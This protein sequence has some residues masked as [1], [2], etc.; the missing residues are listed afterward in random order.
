MKK[1]IFTFF[2]LSQAIL[3]RSLNHSVLETIELDSAPTFFF[4]VSPDGRYY[5]YT[6]PSDPSRPQSGGYNHIYDTHTQRAHRIPGPWD[7]VFNVGSEFIT[8]P[9]Q[10][11]NTYYSFY[12]IDDVLEN[13]RSAKPIGSDTKLRGL[14]QSIGILK[15][16]N[17]EIV[18]RIIAE[19]INNH[20]MRDYLFSK[21]G[22][23]VTPIGPRKELCPKKKI[24]L[25]MI[26]KDGQ[27]LGA[28][29][30]QTGKTTVY[31][32]Q[33]D[34]SCHKLFDLGQKFGKVNFSFDKRY[35]TFHKYNT[36]KPKI[37][38]GFV[39]IP[40]TKTTSDIYIYDRT[41]KKTSQLTVNKK[42]NSL[43]PDFLIDGNLTYINYPH[44]QNKKIH[45]VKIQPHLYSINNEKDFLENLP[46]ENREKERFREYVSIY[47]INNP[48]IRVN[49][50]KTYQRFLPIVE[51]AE[52]LWPFV[53]KLARN[54]FKLSNGNILR[55][56]LRVNPQLAHYLLS[57][58]RFID[59]QTMIKNLTYD[60]TEGKLKLHPNI[61]FSLKKFFIRSSKAPINNNIF[62]FFAKSFEKEEDLLIDLIL[63]AIDNDLSFIQLNLF[64]RF[65][66]NDASIECLEILAEAH[67]SLDQ[68]EAMKRF[69]NSSQINNLTREKKTIL[70]RYALKADVLEITSYATLNKLGV[71]LKEID[72]WEQVL[73]RAQQ[74]GLDSLKE[75]AILHFLINLN[76]KKSIHKIA[77][78]FQ[79][80]PQKEYAIN[81]LQS[82]IA[83]NDTDVLAEQW[84]LIEVI[85]NKFT[86][87]INI[88]NKL[89]SQYKDT[90]IYTNLVDYSLLKEIQIDLPLK[91]QVNFINR[92]S[93]TIPP[94]ISLRIIEKVA[95]ESSLKE[96]LR[97]LF[98]EMVLKR[99]ED[100][101]NEFIVGFLDSVKI[102]T[103][104][105]DLRDLKKVKKLYKN[106]GKI[107]I[108]RKAK[109]YIKSNYGNGNA[110]TTVGPLFNF[111]SSL[112][113]CTN[114]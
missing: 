81:I 80:H 23:S 110:N 51:K 42:S 107:C 22:R 92:H 37:T 101:E 34:G 35:L 10:R 11:E 82:L 50:Y 111:V 55:E 66:K 75:E 112:S 20:S 39:A 84:S 71:L 3:A 57:E 90:F 97:H 47:L 85:A 79:D 29:D 36:N 4:K 109:K 46:S 64:A 13:G 98:N 24:K 21:G 88:F 86:L 52:L 56:S 32:I 94:H 1:L 7:P 15:E 53:Q 95:M 49:S 93:N 69:L 17:S 78:L 6:L 25:P 63:K 48:S 62:N 102:S 2:L 19:R 38:E 5:S 70:Y 68:K 60:Y 89:L 104:K 28:L 67:S 18:Y 76:S 40:S 100:F 72:N 31:K 26:S 33:N 41:F 96:E 59:Y 8:L 16:N 9:H 44:N 12:R 83:S 114:I 27:E 43:Y 103:T 108:Y 87:P 14:Y 91:K 99:P 45:F 113:G 77:E 74:N 106:N 54:G 105:Q 30:I 58:E 61:E 73:D 65:Y